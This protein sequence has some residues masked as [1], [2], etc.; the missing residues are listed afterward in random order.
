MEAGGIVE[1]LRRLR[2]THERIAEVIERDRSAA[3]RLLAG[4]RKVQPNEIEPLLR[5]IAEVQEGAEPLAL[6][7]PAP[8]ETTPD[9]EYAVI[10]ALP[11][12]PGSPAARPLFPRT[13][14]EALGARPQDLRQITV[15]GDAMAPMFLNGDCLLIDLRDRSAAQGGP[16]AMWVDGDDYAVR[17]VQRLRDHSRF[18]VQA[19]NP[20]YPTE[21]LD[22]DQV[23]IMGRPVW[24]SRRL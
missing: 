7:A 17:L 15:R 4:K 14:L 16:F 12:F 9:V 8:P 23:R 3:T 20:A 22:A 11:A 18:R 10:Q 6:L 19:V 13:L 5:L 24:M 21:D 1:A 2:V